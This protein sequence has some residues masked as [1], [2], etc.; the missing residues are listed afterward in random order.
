[1]ESIV[2][3]QSGI[4]KDPSSGLKRPFKCSMKT[5]TNLVSAFTP[6]AGLQPKRNVKL[7]TF[8]FALPISK[9]YPLLDA[10][11]CPSFFS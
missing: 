11:Y 5:F 1:M 2:P 10:I 7:E 8:A 6:S 3:R 9:P 4:N